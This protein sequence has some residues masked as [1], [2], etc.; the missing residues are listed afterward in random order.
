MARLSQYQQAINKIRSKPFGAFTKEE[1]TEIGKVLQREANRRMN[2]Y[3]KWQAHTG[4]D[5][6]AAQRAYSEK[7]WSMGKI[8]ITKG[9][10]GTE[11]HT[12][13]NTKLPENFSKLRS[14]VYETVRFL[15][16][17]T[18]TLKG[19]EEAYQYSIAKW[20]LDLNLIQTDALWRVVEELRK[21]Y[22]DLNVSY[23]TEVHQISKMVKE[24]VYEDFKVSDAKFVQLY[25]KAKEMVDKMRGTESYTMGP[26]VSMNHS[27]RSIF[28]PLDIDE[29]ED[30]F[31]Y[32][33]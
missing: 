16:A 20:G 30:D 29:D 12:I 24:E 26:A 18:S 4:V 8:D 3:S 17:K 9:P 7:L 25:N 15:E 28:S 10:N 6:S 21:V 32:Y 5:I 23:T 13:V 19:I 22:P 31:D 27:N 11:I 14:Y 33:L 1:L 2:V